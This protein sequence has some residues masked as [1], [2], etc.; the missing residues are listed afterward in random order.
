MAETQDQESKGSH[1]ARTVRD[2]DA[3]LYD[4]VENCDREV[5]S[6]VYSRAETP[7]FVARW[8]H[9]PRA[10]ATGTVSVVPHGG[11]HE[12]RCVSTHAAAVWCGG[13]NV[14]EGHRGVGRILA[15]I[16]S[17]LGEQQEKAS[18]A[19]PVSPIPPWRS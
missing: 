11:S 6:Q 13:R 7:P 16:F 17:R 19:K 15:F 1:C 2:H 14:V 3:T 4:F 18:A 5:V 8:F 12:R 9:Q 10:L